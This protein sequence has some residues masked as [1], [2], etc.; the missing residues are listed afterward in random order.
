MPKKKKKNPLPVIERFTCTQKPYSSPGRVLRSMHCRVPILIELCT[1]EFCILLST[2]VI[3]VIRRVHWWYQGKSIFA[4]ALAFGSS[5]FHRSVSFGPLWRHFCIPCGSHRRVK[6][7]AVEWFLR[8]F[9]HRESLF[10]K[11]K[12]NTSALLL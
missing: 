12:Q 2:M 6:A 11:K 8:L 9:I 7:D 4:K 1:R 5:S 3:S 10:L